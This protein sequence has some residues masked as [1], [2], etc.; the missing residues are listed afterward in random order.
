MPDWL[1]AVLSVCLISYIALSAMLMPANLLLD[2]D[3]RRK[4]AEQHDVFTCHKVET[5]VPGPAPKG[6]E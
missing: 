6:S 1:L 4:C 2:W 5:W 3:N